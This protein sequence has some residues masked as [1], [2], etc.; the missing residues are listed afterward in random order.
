MLVWIEECRRRREAMRA[1]RERVACL[2]PLLPGEA[3]RLVVDYLCR[4][5]PTRCPPA[6]R[7]ASSNLNCGVGW[8]RGEHD[9]GLCLARQRREKSDKMSDINFLQGSTSLRN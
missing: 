9:A 6:A 8:K 2:P 1:H 3:K 7:I 4:R 5:S